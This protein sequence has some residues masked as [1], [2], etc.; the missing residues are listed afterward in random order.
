MKAYTNQG[1]T[2]KFST[3]FF[4][5]QTLPFNTQTTYYQVYLNSNDNS[6]VDTGSSIKPTP[7]P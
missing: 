1:F 3:A 6:W 7:R 5:G 2:R 4:L